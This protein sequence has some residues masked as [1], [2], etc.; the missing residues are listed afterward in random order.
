MKICCGKKYSGC[1]INADAWLSEMKGTYPQ[2]HE[3]GHEL[4]QRV[5]AERA[6]A[7]R[8]YQQIAVHGQSIA[9]NQGE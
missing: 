9:M 3:L 2:E 5:R 8:S 7:L 6:R 1:K 4:E